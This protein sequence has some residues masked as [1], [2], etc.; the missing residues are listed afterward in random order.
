MARTAHDVRYLCVCIDCGQFGDGRKML[1]MPEGS[2]H[3]GCLIKRLSVGQVLRLPKAQR[4]KI[5]FGAAGPALMRRL[6]DADNFELVK[7]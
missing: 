5:T 2:Y 1:D 7:G 4:A 6:L 3:D